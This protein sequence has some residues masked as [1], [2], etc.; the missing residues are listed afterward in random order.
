MK[1]YFEEGLTDAEV[2]RSLCSPG[3]RVSLAGVDPKQEQ[4]RRSNTPHGGKRARIGAPLIGQLSANW[5]AVQ[6]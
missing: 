4:V 6:E 1:D 2:V 5:V 3:F